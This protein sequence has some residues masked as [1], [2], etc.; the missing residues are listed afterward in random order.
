MLGG[1]MCARRERAEGGRRVWGAQTHA[2][3]A[4]HGF[5]QLQYFACGH[6]FNG[7]LS[8]GIHRGQCHLGLEV[9]VFVRLV[10]A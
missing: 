6:F 8:V 7:N 5:A 10:V 2:A 3:G 1:R 9:S 4:T